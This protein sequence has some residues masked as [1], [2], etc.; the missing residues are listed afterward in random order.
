MGRLVSLLVKITDARY[1]TC[2]ISESGWYMQ[3]GSEVCGLKTISLLREA[4]DNYGLIGLD[5][6]LCYRIL[7][8]LHRFV[9]FFRTNVSKSAIFLEQLRDEVRV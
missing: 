6:L 2:S 4:I 8:E 9:K 3:D 5:H 7:H 1:T